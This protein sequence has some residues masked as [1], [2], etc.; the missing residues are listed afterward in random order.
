MLMILDGWGI[1]P[2]GPGIAVNLAQKP[3]LDRLL[4][5]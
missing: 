1:D 4:A 5:E 3:T 2:S